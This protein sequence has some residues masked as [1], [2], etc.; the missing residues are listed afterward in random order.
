M[1]EVLL[2]KHA[3]G[4][5]TFIHTGNNPLEYF[6]SN[7]GEGWRF[8]IK[9]GLDENVQEILK[10][11]T[12][13]NV[14]LFQDYEDLPTKKIWFYTKGIVDYNEQAQELSIEAESKIEY[15]PDEFSK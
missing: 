4:G 11:K 15:V 14:F 5:R 7:Q 9:V 6:V 3:V 10:W 2:V 13:L 8:I 1:N 12:E